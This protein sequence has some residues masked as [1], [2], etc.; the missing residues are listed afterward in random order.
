MAADDEVLRAVEGSLDRPS[1]ARVYDYFIGGNHNYAIDR[2]F[3]DKVR[4]RLPLIPDSAVACR[5]FLGRAV[6]Y[7]SKAGIRQYVDIGSGLPTAGNV[8]EVAD[9][10]RPE[11]DTTV[12]YI[13]NE[14]IALAH[15]QLLLADTADPDRHR[16]IAGDLLEP[17]DLW[18]RVGETGVIDFD[19][20]VALV[21]NAVLHFIKDEQRP[22][23]ALDFY[24]DQLAPGSYLIMCQLTDE[25]PA[26]DEERRALDD[27]KAY[28]ETTTNPGQYRSREEFLKF[29][30]DFELVEPGLVYAPEWHP[31][32]HALFAEA[33]SKSRILAAVARKP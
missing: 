32:E 10:A 26:D 4:A 20:P 19:E 2:A 17:I 27:L 28:Y 23:P 12:V 3:G 21:I 22:H 1:A 5:Q 14:P 8:H 33:P 25:N 7:A 16:A 24:R 15:S 31:D 30:G 9:E 29:Y 18:E 11:R 13:D 6:R